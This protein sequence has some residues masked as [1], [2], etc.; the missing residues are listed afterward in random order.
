LKKLTK[1]TTSDSAYAPLTPAQV[2][3]LTDKLYDKRKA[4]ALEVEK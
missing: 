2:R 3:A 1:M 4:A